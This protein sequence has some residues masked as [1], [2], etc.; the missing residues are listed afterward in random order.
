MQSAIGSEAR[1]RKGRD[2]GSREKRP[3]TNNDVTMNNVAAAEAAALF[4]GRIES[5]SR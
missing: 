1:R 2:G 5:G 3:M 4:A